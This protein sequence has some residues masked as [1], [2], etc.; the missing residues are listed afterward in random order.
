MHHKISNVFFLSFHQKSEVL[1][2]FA[3]LLLFIYLLILIIIFTDVASIWENVC[4][5][6]SKQMLLQKVCVFCLI[7]FFSKEENNCDITVLH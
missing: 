3:V 5:F 7:Q 1:K 4:G 2:I 6:V